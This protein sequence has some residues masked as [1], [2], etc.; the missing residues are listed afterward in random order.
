MVEIKLHDIGEG[1]TEAEITH[2]LVK[3]G[4]QVMVDQA[5]VEV[6]TDKMTAEIPAPFSGVIKELNVAEGDVVPIG[7]TVLLMEADGGNQE[8]AVALDTVEES[9]IIEKSQLN[10]TQKEISKSST[11]RGV[12][13]APYTRKVAR[14]LSVDI[15]QVEGTGKR[16]RITV[17]DVKR[18]AEV[19]DRQSNQ[20]INRQHDFQSEV[21]TR[22]SIPFR[23]RRKQIAKK[24]TQSFYTIPHVTT[25]E[26]FDVTNLLDVKV[27]LK[28]TNNSIS[29]TAFFIKALSI[30]LKEFPIFNAKLD[31][32]K[33][34]IHFEKEHHF[35][36]AVD[37]E[38]GLIV[39]VIQNVEKK[40]IRAIH[41]EAKEL[42]RKAQINKLSSNEMT[43]S[44]FTIS[45][46]GPLGGSTGAT[47]II[48]Y[49]EVALM[50]FH[51][52]KKR[53]VVIDD[54]IVIRS[55]MNVSLVFD[56]RVADGA[57][58]VNFINRVQSLIEHPHLMMVD[59]V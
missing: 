51:K 54:E 20:Q 48:N 4:D 36:V 14:E 34:L 50:S 39:P 37:A 35:G 29:A 46:V 10:S 53:P 19:G 41:N 55:I 12:K 44:T 58:A 38:E 42:V 56:H 8:A 52:T 16:G 24:M 23:G 13:A 9:K 27:Q 45:N 59:L 47:P 49:P 17:E 31:E 57:T 40:N 5:V 18:F 15:E 26:E 1:M 30:A 28:A 21:D 43:G 6:Q 22:E 25:F 11:K 7:T 3:P 33:E 32:E 2:F